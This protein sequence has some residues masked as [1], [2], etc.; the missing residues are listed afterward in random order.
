MTQILSAL[1]MVVSRCA[2]TIVVRFCV[3]SSWSS[4]SCT[5]RSLSVSSALVASS[6][7]STIGFLMI[8][9]AIATRCFC[10]PDSC[11]PFSPTSVSYLDGSVWMN[12]CAFAD[13]AA[14]SIS[15]IVA[16]SLPYPMFSA[17]VP[18]NSTGSCPTSPICF[19]SQEMLS[20]RRSVP[21]SF[22]LPPSGS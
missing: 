2:I 7:S 18:A 13:L 16:P 8:A 17:I 4:A 12:V 9:R 21:S 20:C 1:R 6:S 15:A 10:P 11:P 14:C 5:I 22:T 19:L 3:A